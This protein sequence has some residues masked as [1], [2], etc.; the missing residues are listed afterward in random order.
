[1]ISEV[2]IFSQGI[3]MP[4]SPSV[5]SEHLMSSWLL[6]LR[7]LLYLATIFSTLSLELS[8]DMSLFTRD[9]LICL[10]SLPSA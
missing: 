8:T 7:K 2:Q 1:M 5:M 10:L 4:E 3:P 9:F 6:F